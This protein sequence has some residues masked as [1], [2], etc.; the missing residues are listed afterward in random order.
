LVRRP[1]HLLVLPQAAARAALRHA[2]ATLASVAT[3]VAE[4]ER[5]ARALRDKGFD[6]IASDANFLLFGRFQDAPAIW[7]AFCDHGV[8]LRDVGIAGYLRATIGT[9]GVNDTF[10][11]ACDAATSAADLGERA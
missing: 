1:Y 8:L 5:V 9:P 6:V 3:L 2:D 11:A 10:L 4:R 7:K